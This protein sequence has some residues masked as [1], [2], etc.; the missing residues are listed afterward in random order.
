MKA[1]HER[2]SN[3]NK[4]SLAELKSLT[5]AH[6]Q[7][8]IDKDTLS[9]LENAYGEISK[10]TKAQNAQA[11]LFMAENK[12]LIAA[13]KE[14]PSMT[15]ESQVKNQNSIMNLQKIKQ[16]ALAIEKSRADKSQDCDIER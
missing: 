2:L 13:L 16:M 3:S 14:S 9:K 1:V 15:F 8:S 4:I 5:S 7:V 12:E 10:N 6:T 11:K